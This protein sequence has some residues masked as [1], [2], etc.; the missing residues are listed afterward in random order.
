MF[1]RTYAYKEKK[2]CIIQMITNQKRVSFDEELS[3]T[4]TSYIR[5]MN[6]IC[7]FTL[8]INDMIAFLK[9]YINSICFKDQR[10]AVG[11]VYKK[12]NEDINSFGYESLESSTDSDTL[13][14]DEYH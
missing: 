10:C 14:Y 13:P 8:C 2:K 4:H 7:R 12:N 3:A 6:L 1:G 9:L 5:S 11:Y